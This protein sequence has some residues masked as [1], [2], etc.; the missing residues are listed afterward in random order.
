VRGA[1]C[2]KLVQQVDGLLPERFGRGPVPR[3]FHPR[4][5]HQEVAH[6]GAGELDLEELIL[7]PQESRPHVPSPE[8]GRPIRSLS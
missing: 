3:L 5:A 8:A 7:I 2:F 4:G 6:A 1:W